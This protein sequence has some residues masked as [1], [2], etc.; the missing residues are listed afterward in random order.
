MEKI[1]KEDF[2]QEIQSQINLSY[3]FVQQ[4]RVIFRDRLDKYIDQNIDDDKIGVNTLY[5][6]VNLSIAIKYSDEIS[7]LCKPRKF[8]DEEYAD[9]LTALA[10]FDHEEMEMSRKDYQKHWDTA[11]F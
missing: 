6:M 3:N 4:K 9:N 5:A 7:V 11:M 1:N 2:L 10:K 8:G